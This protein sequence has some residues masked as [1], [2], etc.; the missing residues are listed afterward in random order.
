M[1]ERSRTHPPHPASSSHHR[2]VSWV[3]QAFAR[4]RLSVG[5][6]VCDQFA[7]A[8]SR[9][10]TARHRACTGQVRTKSAANR[11]DCDEDGTCTARAGGVGRRGATLASKCVAT[12]PVSRGES[13]LPGSRQ[14]LRRIRT[15]AST[16]AGRVL[17]RKAL[18][19]RLQSGMGTGFFFIVIMRIRRIYE[20]SCQ[21]SP[22]T[23]SCGQGREDAHFWIAKGRQSPDL[24]PG[25]M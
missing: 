22:G 20:R 25:P 16:G 7:G 15:V 21:I 4:A 3:A 13:R 19:S 10:C 18:F 24:N 5:G 2:P 1:H 14:R 23:V 11:R 17:P 6:D 12:G 8:N 9:L